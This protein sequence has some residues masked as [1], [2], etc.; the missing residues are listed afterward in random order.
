MAR[1]SAQKISD[2]LIVLCI[3]AL[4][5]EMLLLP[6]INALAY[7][8]SAVSNDM[9]FDHL[10]SLF[11]YDL[12][13]GLG[14]LFRISLD[15]LKHPPAAVLSL[16]LWIVAICAALILVQGIRVLASVA[17]GSPF[18][19]K[20]AAFLRRAGLA[21]FIISAGALG[22]TVFTLCWEGNCALTSYTVLFIP[23]FAMAGLLCLVFSVLFRQAAEMKAENDLTI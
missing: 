22:R 1:T 21:C 5:T 12:D 7:F 15:S 9:T 6:W 13:D 16:F 11:A 3:L 4:I 10:M 8:Q 23:L 2:I 19:S 18:S 20:N 17:D 14:N